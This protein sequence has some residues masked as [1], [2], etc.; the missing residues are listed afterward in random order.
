M[1]SSE[2]KGATR[3]MHPQDQGFYVKDTPWASTGADE[4]TPWTVAQGSA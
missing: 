4:D 3:Y 2:L 1:S